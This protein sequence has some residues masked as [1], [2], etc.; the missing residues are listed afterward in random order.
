MVVPVSAMLSE[1]W[2]NLVLPVP[3]G[4]PGVVPEVVVA[5]NSSRRGKLCI[6][7]VAV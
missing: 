4:R 6:P 7:T 1:A 2:I 5:V 3:S